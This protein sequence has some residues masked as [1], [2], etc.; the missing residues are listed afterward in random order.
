MKDVIGAELRRLVTERAQWTCEYCLLHEDDAFTPHQ[1][2]HVISRKHGG[3]SLL[4]NLAL[5]CVRC[6]AFKGS[7]IASFG[8]DGHVV[9]PLFHPRRQRWIEHFEVQ[10]ALIQPF[11]DAGAATAS[12]LRFNTAARIAERMLLIR[13]GRYPGIRLPA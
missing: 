6:N 3:F 4:D 5:A 9:V 7:D 11:T 13:S 8:L 2:D 1:I 12:L 10:G